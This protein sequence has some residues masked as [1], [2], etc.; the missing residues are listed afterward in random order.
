[1]TAAVLAFPRKKKRGRKLACGPKATVSVIYEAKPN[2]KPRPRGREDEDLM[3]G[4]AFQAAK[5]IVRRQLEEDAYN[6]WLDGSPTI[7]RF[8]SDRRFRALDEIARLRGDIVE[9]EETDLDR[10]MA[11][12]A[13]DLEPLRD[14][15]VDEFGPSLL[16]LEEAPIV[17]LS[18]GG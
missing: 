11:Q 4:L 17:H 18:G 14:Q 3:R 7:V 2:P 9:V 13:K 5:G 16:L 10:E 1:M 8:P 12:L 15:F 6:A